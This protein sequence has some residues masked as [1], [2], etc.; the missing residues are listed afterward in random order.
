MKGI[1]QL[2][3]GFIL[4]LFVCLFVFVGE[5]FKNIVYVGVGDLAQW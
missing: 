5:A 3:A 2:L 4:S 1:S